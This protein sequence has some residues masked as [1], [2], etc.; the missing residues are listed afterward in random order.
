MRLELTDLSQMSGLYICKWVL[1]KWK[2]H[3]KTVVIAKSLHSG[4]KGQYI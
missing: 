2:A 1:S 4:G 3:G